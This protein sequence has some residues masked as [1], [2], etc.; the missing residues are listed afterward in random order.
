MS[1]KIHIQPPPIE[2]SNEPL[3]RVIYVIDVG[4]VNII[5]AAMNAYEIMS[6][7]DS[8]PPILEVIDNKGNK[9]KIDLSERK[10]KKG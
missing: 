10:K 6:D 1:K 5:E 3:F 4:A 8:L 9:I 7:S 2:K